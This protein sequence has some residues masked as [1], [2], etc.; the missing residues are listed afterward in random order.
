MA[1]TIRVTVPGAGP[2]KVVF[3]GGTF[4]VQL[5]KAELPRGLTGEYDRDRRRYLVRF[6]YLSKEPGVR[7]TADRNGVWIEEGRYSGNILSISVPVK[8]EV[9]GFAP[10]TSSIRTALA[11]RG[12]RLSGM[13]MIG[14][15][16]NQLVAEKM[17]DDR[18]VVD[19]LSKD[20]VL[21]ARSK[22]GS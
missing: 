18:N 10:L 3:G 2:E 11:E 14:R 21:S 13:Q 6:D 1:K 9:E 19:S 22:V 12:T 16:L 17:F 15:K 7:V 4:R 20:L 8:D 5:P